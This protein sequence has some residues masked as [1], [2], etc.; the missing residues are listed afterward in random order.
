MEILAYPAGLGRSGGETQSL[1]EACGQGTARA[2]DASGLQT[3]GKNRLQGLRLR[4]GG[5]AI[6]AGPSRDAASVRER[7]RASFVAVLQR[8]EL[9][10]VPAAVREPQ[11]DKVRSDCRAEMTR[12][13][14]RSPGTSTTRETEAIP[15]L[16]SPYRRRGEL[17]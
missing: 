13:R 2:P 3:S 9:A 11:P 17:E 6:G 1:Q 14:L 15:L 16:S 4:L 12:R 8:S 10:G 5:P 7:N